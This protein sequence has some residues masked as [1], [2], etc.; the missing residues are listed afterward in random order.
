MKSPAIAAE[1]SKDPS[2]D[3]DAER[4]AYNARIAELRETEYPMLKG[5]NSFPRNKALALT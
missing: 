4:L 5:K 2:R 1:S 3:Y